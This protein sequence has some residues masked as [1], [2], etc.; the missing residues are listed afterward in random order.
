MVRSWSSDFEA[1]RGDGTRTAFHSGRE[2]R[3]KKSPW[4]T[5]C[6]ASRDT[7][8]FNTS[9]VRIRGKPRRELFP[10]SCTDIRIDVYVD[11]SA[12]ERVKYQGQGLAYSWTAKNVGNVVDVCGGMSRKRRRNDVQLSSLIAIGRARCC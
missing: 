11:E 7:N 8:A 1:G 2:Q 9:S 5:T 12:I 3:T 10:A 6:E 4:K